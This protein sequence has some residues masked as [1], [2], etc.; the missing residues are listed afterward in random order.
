M[1]AL[2]LGI[3]VSFGGS[4][5]SPSAPVNISIPVISGTPIVGNTLTASTGTWSG[6]PPP[7]FEY[8]WN[9]DGV[10]IEGE[11]GSTYLVAE[12]DIDGEITVTV[13]ATNDEG[14]DSATSAP[15]IGQSAGG[16]AEPA[17]LLETGDKYLLESGDLMLLEAA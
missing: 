14:F 10:A 2:G 9:L 6:Y 17:Y 13:T 8:Q 1:T 3:G 7:S 4:L 12:T 15:V 5:F 11:T 16:T